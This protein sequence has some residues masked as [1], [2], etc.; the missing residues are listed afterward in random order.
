MMELFQDSKEFSEPHIGDVSLGVWGVR[1]VIP[2]L[3]LPLPCPSCRTVYLRV[4]FPGFFSPLGEFTRQQTSLILPKNSWNSL[5][6]AEGEELL[7][8]RVLPGL[9]LVLDSVGVVETS[10]PCPPFLYQ[11]LHKWNWDGCWWEP[12][13]LRGE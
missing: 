5:L 11:G 7:H 3:L 1:E 8:P 2:V 6:V 10:S 12:R 9:R 13:E 4:P